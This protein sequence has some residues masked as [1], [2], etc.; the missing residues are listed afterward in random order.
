MYIKADS[1]I[2][3]SNRE[4][5]DSSPKQHHWILAMHHCYDPRLGRSRP[6]LSR[7]QYNIADG[8]FTGAFYSVK[9]WG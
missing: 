3:F 6:V 2:K 1:L 7:V 9:T 4:Q 5:L 8:N